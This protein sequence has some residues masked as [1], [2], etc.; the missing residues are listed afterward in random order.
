MRTEQTQVLVQSVDAAMLMG[1][2]LK[3]EKLDSRTKTHDNVYMIRVLVGSLAE[4]DVFVG[5]LGYKYDL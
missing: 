2:L 5:G 4:E 3:G 1:G